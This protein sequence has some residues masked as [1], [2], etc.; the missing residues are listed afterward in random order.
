[1]NVH[2]V[3]HL[4]SQKTTCCGMQGWRCEM[5]SPSHSATHVLVYLLPST[6]HTGSEDSGQTQPGHGCQAPPPGRL[7]YLG[8]SHSCSI[9]ISLSSSWAPWRY[10]WHT[11]PSYSA[12]SRH[13]TCRPSQNSENPRH[14]WTQSYRYKYIYKYIWIN[15]VAVKKA[16]KW[17][18]H[19]VLKLPFSLKIIL[20]EKLS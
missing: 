12:I 9:S 6:S 14:L 8:T 3:A 18:I 10:C 7:T 19:V 20:M 11:R 13:R 4:M 2:C 15:V 16:H 1:M 17:S 5:S